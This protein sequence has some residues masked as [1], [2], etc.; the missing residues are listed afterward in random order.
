MIDLQSKVENI[1]I[2]FRPRS[3]EVSSLSARDRLDL[4]QFH[5]RVW[6]SGYRIVLYEREPGD[7]PEVGSFLSLYRKGEPW[8][9]WS[10]ARLGTGLSAWCAGTSQDIGTFNSVPE[11]L[12]ALLPDAVAGL[13]ED[14]QSSTALL[15]SLCRVS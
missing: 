11:M 7:A 1:V 9:R 10:V 2:A 4:A 6:L 3:P 5:D 15:I 14:D 8:A 13:A 12:R